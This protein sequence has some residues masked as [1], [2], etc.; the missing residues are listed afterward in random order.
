MTTSTLN[1]L[2]L[3][4]IDQ[5]ALVLTFQYL[6]ANFR[7]LTVL[8]LTQRKRGLCITL[9]ISLNFASV[10]LKHATRFWRRCRRQYRLNLDIYK[11]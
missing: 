6:I 7:Q 10:T 8:E 4:G 2:N 1:G 9:P 3:D 5:S 11:R